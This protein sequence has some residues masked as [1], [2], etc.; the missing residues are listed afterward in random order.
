MPTT[1]SKTPQRDTGGR[2]AKGNT[3]GAETTFKPGNTLHSVY[4]PDYPDKLLEYFRDTE[5]PFPT[6]EGFAEKY[7]IAIRT[8]ERWVLSDPKDEMFG[9]MAD[10]YAQCKAIQKRA[11]LVHGLTRSFDAS[12]VKFLLSTNHDMHERSDQHVEADTTFRVEID[13]IDE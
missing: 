1:K 13:V 4:N 2:F 8:L 7:H 12:M 6:L 11:L 10:A 9:R 3:V 5:E